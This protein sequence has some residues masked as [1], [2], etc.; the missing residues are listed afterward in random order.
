M[1]R[2]R[3]E[4]A[5]ASRRECALL[6]IIRKINGKE[7]KSAG[8][9]EINDQVS[10][11]TW[12][13]AQTIPFRHENIQSISEPEFGLEPTVTFVKLFN[14]YGTGT[15]TSVKW[16][17]YA[18]VAEPKNA[19]RNK[20]ISKPLR[21]CETNCGHS[22]RIVE[23]YMGMMKFANRKQES[24]SHQRC[25][26]RKDLQENFI[27]EKVRQGEANYCNHFVKNV[28]EKRMIKFAN[29]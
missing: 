12:T 8:I 25:F 29:F 24:E 22:V 23:I 2:T 14:I 18:L 20:L 9:T 1:R 3:K 28:E 27:S 26:K 5:C 11:C 10:K 15:R 19:L 16:L 13:G 4:T 7:T 6:S 17:Q 21:Q